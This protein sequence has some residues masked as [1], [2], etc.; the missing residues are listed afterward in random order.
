MGGRVW[1]H[2]QVGKGST[3]HLTAR[4]K[5]DPKPPSDVPPRRPWTLRGT[6]VLVADDNA[7]N[8]FILEEMLR[9]WGMVVRS[10]GGAREALR[11]AREAAAA[12]TPF[13][14]LLTDVHMPH[15]DGFGLAEQFR[16]SPDLR[17]TA[18]IALTSGARSSDAARCERLG[19]AA[20][21]MKPVK[22]T[23]L[24][25][26]M[27]DALGLTAARRATSEPEHAAGR[28]APRALH[29]L[30]AEDS[31]V[32]QKLAIGLLERRGHQVTVVNNGREAVAAASSQT[33]DL[34]LMDVQMPEMDG[35][36]ATIGIREL[37]REKGRHVPIV[38]MTAHAMKGDRERCLEAGMDGYVAKPIHAKELFDTIY[39]LTGGSNTARG[40]SPSPSADESLPADG[41]VVWSAVLQASDGNR[42][43]L[44]ELTQI[45]LS[46]CPK[47]LDEGRQAIHCRDAETLRRA[48][49][50][51]KGSLRHFHAT[52][53][54]ENAERLE[55][56]GKSGDFSR[57]AEAWEELER[58][59]HEFTG[60]L[61][62]LL[63][64]DQA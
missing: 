17:E 19:L 5:P 26:A 14:L 8:R 16:E 42:E 61:Q 6:R 12:G 63:R 60:A 18:I 31:L 64:P 55:C 56:M 23:E 43:L 21:L 57:A 54:A 10:A 34:I 51:L 48:A 33:F 27:G 2:S 4:F 35:L 44:L 20:Y 41:I 30:L 11:L 36:E 29:V 32:N 22:Q 25:E 47:L 7:S 40:D 15:I 28:D 13:D 1:A 9:N 24:H 39:G 58:E 62:A 59:L 45:F 46:E 50:T 37:E 38:A 52:R 3:F 53:V 49:H